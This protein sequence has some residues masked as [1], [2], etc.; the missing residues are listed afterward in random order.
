M[1]EGLTS[2]SMAKEAFMM[3]LVS[4]PLDPADAMPLSDDEI[5]DHSNLMFPGPAKDRDAALLTGA[6]GATAGGLG[7]YG[8]G[9]I[10]GDA[11]LKALVGAILGGTVGAGSQLASRAIIR[12]HMRN[13]LETRNKIIQKAKAERDPAY[14]F[15][16]DTNGT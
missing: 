14:Q 13:M 15:D 7:G 6:I 2:P 1:Q 9:K 10:T 12:K 11:P 3:P 5:A 16:A 8:M 4:L